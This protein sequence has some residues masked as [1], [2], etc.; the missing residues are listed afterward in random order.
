MKISSSII[1]FA[2]LAYT[3]PIFYMIH[4]S[5]EVQNQKDKNHRNRIEIINQ[6]IHL[7][8]LTNV[9]NEIE[10]RILD[11]LSFDK[12]VCETPKCFQAE[13]IKL[14]SLHN[15]ILDKIE[16]TQVKIKELE[17]ESPD[18]STVGVGIGGFVLVTILCIGVV[19][20]DCRPNN[21]QPVQINIT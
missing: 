15:N 9:N 8:N 19:L 6:E 20:I 10:S 12:T 14:E 4:G 17:P 7:K 16:N 18:Y 3:L 21:I 2:F 1:V 5:I 13:G 11:I